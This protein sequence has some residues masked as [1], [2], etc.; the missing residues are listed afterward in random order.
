V[1]SALCDGAKLEKAPPMLEGG[2]LL[3]NGRA[4]NAGSLGGKKRRWWKIE[5]A[6]PEIS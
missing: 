4:L 5:K 1:Y 6:Q 3:R 2:E